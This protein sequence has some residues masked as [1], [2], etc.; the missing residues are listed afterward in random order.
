MVLVKKTI[1]ETERW[2]VSY[3]FLHNIICSSFS[4]ST[5]RIDTPGCQHICQPMK[6]SNQQNG[7]QPRNTLYLK[8][9]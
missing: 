5:E 2:Y 9:V 6:S 3:T 8:I 7:H 1:Q 4:T